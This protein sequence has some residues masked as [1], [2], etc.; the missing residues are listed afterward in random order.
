[1]SRKSGGQLILAEPNGTEL[2]DEFLVFA[3]TLT[4][5]TS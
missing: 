3:D 5:T 4:P 1:M 2:E